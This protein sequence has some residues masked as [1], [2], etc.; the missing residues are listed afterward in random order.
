MICSPQGR[1]TPAVLVLNNLELL[2]KTAGEPT[3]DQVALDLA[4]LRSAGVGFL[5][6]Y[7]QYRI[8]RRYTKSDKDQ[9]AVKSQATMEAKL[10]PFIEK[11]ITEEYVQINRPALSLFRVHSAFFSI[12]III[13][14]ITGHN[15]I[16][17]TI[18]LSSSLPQQQQQ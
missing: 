7:L 13:I 16:I 11:G 4:T 15:I 2:G 17:E 14:I 6:S 12:I 18:H 3:K 8:A 1:T 10:T 9:T 5:F